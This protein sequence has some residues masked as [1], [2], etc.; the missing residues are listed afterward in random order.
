MLL[1]LPIA[2]LVCHSIFFNKEMVGYRKLKLQRSPFVPAADVFRFDWSPLNHEPGPTTKYD[3]C[4]ISGMPVYLKCVD[5][6][7]KTYYLR[8]LEISN[9]LFASSLLLSR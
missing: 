7:L 8:T 3:T 5:D 4:L 1:A 6:R 9:G 2:C